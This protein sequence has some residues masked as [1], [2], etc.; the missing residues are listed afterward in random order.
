MIKRRIMTMAAGLLACALT[1]MMILPVLTTIPV[2]AQPPTIVTIFNTSV[3]PGETIIVPVGIMNVDDMAGANIWLLYD[4]N[5][6][7]VED[8]SAG[9]LG[10]LTTG[11]DNTAGET[12]MNW[13]QELGMT[14]DF[15]FAYVTLRAVGS[16]GSTSPLTLQAKDLYNSDLDDISHIVMSGEFT[17]E[18]VVPPYTTGHNPMVDAIG[19]PAYTNI[20]VHVLDD[21]VGVDGDTIIMTVEETE[22]SP[23]VTTTMAGHSLIY[24]PPVDFAYE[25]VVDVTVDAS[26]L[27]G[28]AM[29]TDS[30]SFTIA[31]YADP[32]P[33]YTSGHDPAPDSTD[34]PVDSNILLCV[35][36][37]ETGVDQATIVMTVEEVE[38]TP[39]IT[40]TWAGFVLTYDPPVNFDYLQMVDITVNVSDLAG[41]PM[42][43][44]SYSFITQTEP[45]TNP[46]YTSDHDPAKG[47]TGVPIDTDITVH[48]KD[49]GTGVNKDSIVMT[50]KATPVIPSITGTPAD[51]TLTYDPPAEFGYEEEVIVTIDASDL[52]GNVAPTDSYTFSTQAAPNEPPHQPTNTSPSNDTTD[53]ILTPILESSSFSDPNTNDT[54]IASQW[55]VTEISGDY[56]NP[57]LDSGPYPLGLVQASIP[58]GMLDHLTTYWW[59]VRHQDNHNVW[60]PWSTETCFS[61]EPPLNL[62]PIAEANGPYESLEGS[63]ITLDGSSSYDP[64]G[65]IVQWE[66]DLNNDGIF[67]DAIGPIVEFTWGDDYSGNISLK[68]TDSLGATGIDQTT[69]TILNELPVVEAGAD[70]VSA[71]GKSINFNGEFTDPGQLDSHNIQ[72]EFGD[73]NSASDVLSPS[74]SYGAPGTY[75]VT[76]TITDDDGGIGMDTLT[77]TVWSYIFEDPQRGTML[78][79]NV[80]DKIM[81]FTAPDGFDTGEV[82]NV[83]MVARNNKITIRGIDYYVTIEAG[84]DASCYGQIFDRE[85]GQRYFIYDPGTTV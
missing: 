25:Q 37:S 75:A 14:G 55:Q 4:T 46:P 48:I 64:D 35:Q 84:L 24:D 26:D 11:M 32:T 74:H 23:M 10:A 80:D 68:V 15:A 8:V 57:I 17:I 59:R 21:G 22:V 62:P 38:V 49:N 79:L 34:V 72:W 81:R 28:N 53:T 16:E 61:T 83:D 30:Y 73:G 7:V 42:P 1:L 47:D 54:H 19:V 12:R 9:D 40:E 71:V 20:V 27:G 69:I 56:S 51:Y 2:M 45:D 3:G 60:S 70:Q 41:N 43:T 31:P 33:P 13:D 52:E 29:V 65:Q 76:L 67:D 44:D 6:V 82:N 66:W 78:Y 85:R 63:P 18:D 77:V 5:V 39:A 50:V 58:A 36:D